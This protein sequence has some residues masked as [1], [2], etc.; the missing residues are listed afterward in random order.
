M[1][2][3]IA[4][5]FIFISSLIVL[6]FIFSNILEDDNNVYKLYR[7]TLEGELF[8]IV[9]YTLYCI[10]SVLNLKSRNKGSNILLFGSIGFI[11]AALGDYVF[12]ESYGLFIYVLYI[13]LHSI[14]FTVINKRII[15]RTILAF[16]LLNI[17]LI[18]ALFLIFNVQLLI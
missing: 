15:W 14:V 17:A 10:G 18:Y 1:Y 13:I 8:V 2:Y 12:I 3:K 16:C 6:I 5:Y 4:N 11:L 9:Y 7:Y